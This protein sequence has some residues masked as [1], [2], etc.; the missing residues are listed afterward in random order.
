MNDLIELD[1]RVDGVLTP[2]TTLTLPL[3]RR[4][5]CRQRVVLDDGRDAGV[6]LARGEVLHDGDL[7]GSAGGDLVR[8][9]AA[10][11]AV[12]EVRCD[13]PLLLARACYHLGNRH[14]MLQLGPGL[15]RYRHDHVLDVMLRG[16]GL[17]PAFVEAPFEPEPGAYGGSAHGH[18]HSHGHA[19]HGH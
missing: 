16:L 15:L 3:D 13:D 19:S 1:R 9:C 14:V 4:V 11:E 8:V 6:F 7:L 5:R 18:E 12:S 10:P 17:S 2:D